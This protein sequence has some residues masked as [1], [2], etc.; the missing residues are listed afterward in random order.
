MRSRGFQSGSQ[1]VYLPAEYGPWKGVYTRLRNWAIDGTWERVFTALFAQAG[2]EGDLD[3]VVAVDSTIVR[4]HQHGAGTR[5]RE[6]R[7][8]SPP[9]MRSDDLG[10][11]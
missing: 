3:W 4:V 11:D 2:A 9:I 1:W 7:L 6:R 5:K 8:T 10:G